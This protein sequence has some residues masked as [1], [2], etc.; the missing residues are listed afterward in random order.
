MLSISYQHS[1]IRKIRTIIHRQKSSLATIF[2][3]FN[4][5]SAKSRVFLRISFTKTR[6]LIFT[7]KIVCLVTIACCFN[8][9]SESSLWR[10]NSLFRRDLSIISLVLNHILNNCFESHSQWLN[11]RVMTITIQ[12][13]ANISLFIIRMCLDHKLKC[14]IAKNH[15]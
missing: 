12:R 15:W 14:L 11:T 5:K 7:L 1:H 6:T 4:L 8:R 10:W 3:C 13:R 9:K 2:C